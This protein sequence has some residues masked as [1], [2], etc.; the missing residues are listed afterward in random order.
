MRV[1]AKRQWRKTAVMARSS[2]A[3]SAAR[4][5]G[6]NLRYLKV[7]PCRFDELKYF[8]NSRGNV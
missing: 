2:L 3:E 5:S 7:A 4:K 1:V 8:A 6:K